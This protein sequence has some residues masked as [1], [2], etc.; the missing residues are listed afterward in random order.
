MADT[1]LTYWAIRGLGAPL[2]MMLTY[3]G[4]SYGEKRYVRDANSKP[5]VVHRLGRC[6]KP[7]PVAQH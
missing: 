4:V 2:R 5:T 7:L 6:R 1:T 3:G